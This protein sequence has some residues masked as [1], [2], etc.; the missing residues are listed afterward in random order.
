MHHY[1]V[2]SFL[3]LKNSDLKEAKLTLHNKNI[4]KQE[5]LHTHFDLNEQKRKKPNHKGLKSSQTYPCIEKR[6]FRV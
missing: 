3:I 6:A 5:T 4:I 1:I 2:K